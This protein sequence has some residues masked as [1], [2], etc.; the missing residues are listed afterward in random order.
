MLMGVA[1][2]EV[3]AA[4][5]A[6]T[7]SSLALS[8]SRP[9]NATGPVANNV[10]YTFTGS[11]VSASAIQCVEEVYSA[12][13]N[14]TPGATPPTG[15]VTTGASYDSGASNWATFTGWTLDASSNGKLV[16]HHSSAATPTAGTHTLAFDGVRNSTT[17]DTGYWM[18]ITTY[19]GDQS[20]GAGTDCSGAAVDTATVQFIITNGQLMSLTVDGA[21]SFTV[22]GQA[23]G[24]CGATGATATVDLSSTPNAIG[25]GTVNSG[26]AIACQELS[27]AT[28]ATNG[29]TVN[30]RDTG[31]LQNALAQKLPDNATT[32]TS[33]GAFATLTAGGNQGSY[34]YT[35][36]D[37]SL[38]GGT[39]DRF[40]NSGPN[41]AAFLHG[42]GTAA[43]D[44]AANQPVGDVTSPV[45][46]A[47][48]DF[49]IADQVGTTALTQPGY[50]T[51]TVVYTCT[52]VY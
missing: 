44:A 45:T 35:T 19:A 17:T 41:W 43:G 46:G 13:S 30:M 25:F 16:F 2:P 21:L 33:P 18:T 40:T 14:T 24:A 12:T 27:G 38:G 10:Q 42:D 51:T 4:S 23:A 22:A 49:Y 50:Y 37:S 6:L 5:N 52:P 39:A 29:F 1:I 34:A 47:S 26:N 20:G 48:G 28:N 3:A 31:Q 7:S 36:D 11:G 32:N 8:D 9:Y 15:M